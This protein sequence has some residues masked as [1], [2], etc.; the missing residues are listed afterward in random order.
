[1]NC[2]SP[3]F[4]TEPVRVAT[5]ELKTVQM[6]RP[7]CRDLPI[8]IVDDLSK[9]DANFRFVSSLCNEASRLG[10]AVL[11]M[12][13]DKAWANEMIKEVNCGV[14]VVPMMTIIRNPKE[15]GDCSRFSEVPDW[16]EM[17]WGLQDL[18]N[19]AT[20]ENITDVTIEDGMTPEQVLLHHESALVPI[21][22][23]DTS[24]LRSIVW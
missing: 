16:N 14:K 17:K 7:N 23:A 10:V 15:R 18:T 5:A 8:L 21:S 13:R 9:S 1:L 11:V 4:E 12:T 2:L 20:L 24:D 19:F 3:A 22:V 6:L